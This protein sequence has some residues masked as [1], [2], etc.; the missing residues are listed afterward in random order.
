M[1][2]NCK[3]TITQGLVFYGV[4]S[5]HYPDMACYGIVI[6]ARCDLAQKKVKQVHY[7]TAV[8]INEWLKGDCLLIISEELSKNSLKNIKNWMKQKS[9][10]SRV[11]AEFGP[12]KCQKIVETY[13]ISRSGKEKLLKEI[14]MWSL[15]KEISEG[16][17]SEDK[18]VELLNSDLAG[19]KKNKLS[20]L[21]K[22]Q[23]S[24]FYLLPHVDRK[25]DGENKGFV[26][27]LRDIQS[28]KIEY[29]EKL[30]ANEIDFFNPIIEKDQNIRKIFFLESDSDFA[31]DL[32]II[33]SPHIEHLM[34]SFAH[35]YSRIGI[36][37]L[38]EEYE[39]EIK[40]YCVCI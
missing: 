20:L 16:R 34:Q 8:T 24:G 28:M 7:V 33:G 4:R 30:I 25:K 32:G 1:V 29:F 37:D 21:L 13:E 15:A 6:T 22:N 17:I 35:L 23:L 38:T 5:Y 2:G 26:V 18:I 31:M 3:Q 19:Y 40:N 14:N 36:E 39:E 9:L 11:V 10:N 27:N 12:Q